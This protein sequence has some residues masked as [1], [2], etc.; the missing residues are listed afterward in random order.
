MY[1]IITIGSATQDVYLFSK[2]FR[3]CK[4]SRV[5]TGE[6][7]S[8]AF[9][10]KIELDDILFEIGGG[11]TNTAYTF[12]RQGLKVACLTKVGSDG[13]GEEVKKML[14]KAKISTDLVI[15][16]PKHRTA[17]SVIFLGQNGERTILVYRGASHEFRT[18]DVI[19]QKLKNTKWFFITSIGG[20]LN[21]LRKI[22]YFA[23]KNKIKVAL[24]P[25]KL[26]LEHG[27]NK[28]KQIFKKVDILFLNKEEAAEI[29]KRSYTDEKGI[30]NDMKDISSGI[31][32]V[33]EA[34]KGALVCNGKNKFRLTIRPLKAVD[35]TGAGDAYGSGFVAG[36]IKKRDIQFAI[37]LAAANSAGEVMKIGAKQGLLSGKLNEFKKLLRL[38]KLKI[39]KIK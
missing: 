18:K 20:N 29:L 30:I 37:K 13:A 1:D 36:Y 4:D 33:T 8:F 34:E 6:V 5:T 16:D 27:F 31:I 32:V 28:L 39:E 11:A 17:H 22:V 3:I 38:L 19:F 12:I 23:N 15:T 7:E 14:R 26:E 10:T 21:L 25:G 35:T 2:K 24:N 9:G